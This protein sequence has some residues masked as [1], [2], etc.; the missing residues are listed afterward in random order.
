MDWSLVVQLVSGVGAA[1]GVYIGIRID[2]TRMHEKIIAAN[3]RIDA[4]VSDI[5]KAHDRI[6]NWYRAEPRP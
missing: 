6:D 1:L 4:T 2:L 3:A 5:S